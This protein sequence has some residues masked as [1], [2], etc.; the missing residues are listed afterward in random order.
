M[1]VTDGQ[2]AS[3]MGP[4]HYT[5]GRWEIH[6]DRNRKMVGPDGSFL[7]GSTST[8]QE[9]YDNLVG[10]V[11]LSARDAKR[12]TVTNPRKAIGSV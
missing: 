10:G 11:G 12:L 8:M 9:C 7:L 1:V 6:V 2:A 4:G 5:L 3:G